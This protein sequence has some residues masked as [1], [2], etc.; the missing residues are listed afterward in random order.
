MRPTI[1]FT[2]IENSA[3]RKYELIKENVLKLKKQSITVSGKTKESELM[4]L[5]LKGA[6][7]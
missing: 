2:L 1:T 6:L 5:R 3:L 7:E 4:K